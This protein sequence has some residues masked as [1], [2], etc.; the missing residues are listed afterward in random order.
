MIDLGGALLLARGLI[1]RPA[2]LTRRLR[3]GAMGMQ[4]R[5]ELGGGK[6]RR[7]SAGG[8]LTGEPMLCDHGR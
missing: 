8:L 3:G 7:A 6:E 2:E 1:N 4:R 5:G